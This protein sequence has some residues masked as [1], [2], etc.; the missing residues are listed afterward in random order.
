[1]RGC[2]RKI[3]PFKCCTVI[4]GD[5]EKKLA[6]IPPGSIDLVVTDPPYGMNL[7]PSRDYHRA[8]HGDDHFPVE[9]LKRIIAIPRIAAY[10]FCRWDNLW[11]HD[12]L[13]KPKSVLVWEKGKGGT[14]DTAHEHSR[15]YEMVLFYPGP[16]HRFIGRPGDF[17]ATSREGN[18]LHPTAKPPR[19]I[20]QM[21]QWYDFDTVLDPFMGGGTTAQ[22]AQSL[23]KHFLG[24]EI[25]E[26]YQKDATDL[27]ER[28]VTS[29][30][31]NRG[32]H[33]PPLP[34]YK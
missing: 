12:S 3:G 34:L 27:I 1:M 9:T 32:W 2:T 23:G 21:L 30:K 33:T 24:F 29:S 20:R 8:I 22:A 25:D 18:H 15:D 7:K 10:L 26:E 28:E 14:G 11:D 6:K 4:L 16:K 31:P 13:P 5:C 17:V 19:L